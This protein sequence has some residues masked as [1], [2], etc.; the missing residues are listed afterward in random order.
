M[1]KIPTYM[2]RNEGETAIITVYVDDILIAA[3]TNKK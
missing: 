1:E 2:L 3:K